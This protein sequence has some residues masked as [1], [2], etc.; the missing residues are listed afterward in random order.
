MFIVP[1]YTVVLIIINIIALSVA[2]I[3][4]S[5]VL[6]LLFNPIGILYLVT[7]YFYA[8]FGLIA[9]GSVL[10]LFMSEHPKIKIHAYILTLMFFFIYFIAG[11]FIRI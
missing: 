5:D 7:W 8:L 11:N 3:P 1:P 4:L 6:V 9:I 10:Y 2:G